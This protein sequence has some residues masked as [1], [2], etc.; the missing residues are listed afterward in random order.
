MSAEGAEPVMGAELSSTP[1]AYDYWHNSS[2]SE[3]RLMGPNR[4][5]QSLYLD[6]PVEC[7]IMVMLSS[8]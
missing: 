3:R 6:F 4:G 8:R 2:G 7:V 1:L 5:R